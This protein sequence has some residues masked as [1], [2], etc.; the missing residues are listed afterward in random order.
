MG[1]KQS[2]QTT[3]ETVAFSKGLFETIGVVAGSIW[4]IDQAVKNLSEAVLPTYQLIYT[5]PPVLEGLV[6]GSIVGGTVAYAAPMVIR[7]INGLMISMG[8]NPDYSMDDVDPA[9]PAAKRAGMIAG[10]VA[11]LTMTWSLAVN[12]FDDRPTPKIKLSQPQ[13]TASVE[14]PAPPNLNLG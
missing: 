12:P 5:A 11:A 9:H 1:A 8:Q 6:S 3:D 10:A 2:I 7:H 4:G 14:A 13:A